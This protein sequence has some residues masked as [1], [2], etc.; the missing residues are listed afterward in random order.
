M[1][2]RTDSSRKTLTEVGLDEMGQSPEAKTMFP[3]NMVRHW[4]YEACRALGHVVRDVSRKEEC[5][6]VDEDVLAS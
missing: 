5:G 6:S 1:D 4:M 2:L 3:S